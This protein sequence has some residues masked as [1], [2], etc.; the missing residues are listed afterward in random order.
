[1][2]FNA[3]VNAYAVNGDMVNA[4]S[5]SGGSVVVDTAAIAAAVWASP[6]ATTLLTRM[7]EA[8]GRLGLDATAPLTTSNT[9]INFGSV[10]LDLS[11]DSQSTTL[12]R[13]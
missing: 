3:A 4:P 8:W 10:S 7:A 6:S 9:R 13:I 12:T 5:S 2:S 1:M 11:G